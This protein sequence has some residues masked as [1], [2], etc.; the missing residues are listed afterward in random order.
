MPWKTLTAQ[1]LLDKYVKPNVAKTT[2]RTYIYAIRNFLKALGVETIADAHSMKISQIEKKLE[3]IKD[4]NVRS[5]ALSVYVS[6]IK[7]ANIQMEA[8]EMEALRLLNRSLIIKKG[9]TMEKGEGDAIP[10]NFK[11]KVGSYLSDPKNKGT[12]Q[13]VFIACMALAPAIRP[14]QFEDVKVART[15]EEFNTL[16]DAGE[17]VL[18]TYSDVY[19]LYTKAENRKVKSIDVPVEY[20]G[21]AMEALKAYIKP[22]QTVL[23]PSKKYPLVSIGGQ[24]LEKAIKQAFKDAD[25]PA[26]A[27]KLRRIVETQN[28]NDPT[29][30]REEKKAFSEQMNHSRD[31]GDKYKIVEDKTVVRTGEARLQYKVYGMLMAEISQLMV[32]VSDEKEIEAVNM[33]LIGIRDRLKGVKPKTEGLMVSY[34]GKMKPL[35]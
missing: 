32:K 25:I 34:R 18:T 21:K 23:F 5:K 33:K 7:Y 1:E 27:Q 10:N 19:K 20:S 8:S 16:K 15:V 14:G 11:D 4:L 6:I 29:K 30:S 24:Q 31:M 9:A 26:N 28:Q 12:R 13:S 3:G 2:I 17:S 35:I 22:T